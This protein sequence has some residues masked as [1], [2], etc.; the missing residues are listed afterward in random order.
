LG[1]WLRQKEVNPLP[2]YPSKFDKFDHVHPAL[3]RFGLGNEGLRA[4][5]A[6]GDFDLRE[7]GVVPRV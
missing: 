5:E 4:S 1:R 2:I 7:P 3:A 6:L